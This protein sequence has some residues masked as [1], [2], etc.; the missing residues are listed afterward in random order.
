MSEN[1]EFRRGCIYYLRGNKIVG[2]V[3]WNASDLLESAREVIRLQQLL[4]VPEKELRGKIPLAPD[5][6]LKVISE[7]AEKVRGVE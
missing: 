2:V 3:L 7:K 4:D 6:W 1:S 5:A